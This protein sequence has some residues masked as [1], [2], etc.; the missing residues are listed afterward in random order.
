MHHRHLAGDKGLAL[1]LSGGVGWSL[2]ERLGVW[3]TLT[4]RVSRMPVI[5]LNPDCADKARAARAGRVRMRV[6]ALAACIG[7]HTGKQEHKRAHKHTPGGAAHPGPSS[8]PVLF[9]LLVSEVT[10]L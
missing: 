8:P 9:Q 3:M 7:A 6:C 4:V 10:Q 1:I 2:W 5:Q